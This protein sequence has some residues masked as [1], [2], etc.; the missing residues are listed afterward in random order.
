MKKLLIIFV[1]IILLTSC[2]NAK[3]IQET[4]T[5]QINNDNLKYKINIKGKD[6]KNIQIEEI[7][8][9][10]HIDNYIYLKFNDLTSGTGVYYDRPNGE[11]LKEFFSTN[12][13]SEYL[14]KIP[15]DFFNENNTLVISF[16]KNE[17]KDT[18]D[19]FVLAEN[20]KLCSN[21]DKIEEIKNKYPN[22]FSNNIEDI[23]DVITVDDSQY[24]FNSL[25]IKNAFVSVNNNIYSFSIRVNSDK[26]L[27][28]EASVAYFDSN[29]G[30][31]LDSIS[32]GSGYETGE[33]RL[34]F[35]VNK[36][37]YIEIKYIKIS[38]WPNGKNGFDLII[39]GDIL[40][41]Q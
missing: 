15:Y 31:L 5:S 11:K 26:N 16:S 6:Y 4:N 34:V 41:K 17:W 19:I 14:I 29:D 20:F 8:A 35:D 23:T 22:I 27:N 13:N 7:I 38:F 32:D 39:P 40:Y 33:Y 28:S 1:T 12:S 24:K 2:S 25:D 10:E 21:E 36:S 9:F 3:T 37:K 30:I 18:A